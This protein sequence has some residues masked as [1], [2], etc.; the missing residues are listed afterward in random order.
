[1][2]LRRACISLNVLTDGVTKVP[3]GYLGG[4]WHFCHCFTPGISKELEP[5]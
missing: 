3:E 2:G 5:G 4:F 1:V